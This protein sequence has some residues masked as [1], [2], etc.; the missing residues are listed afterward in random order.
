VLSGRI[1][2]PGTLRDVFGR[3]RAILGHERNIQ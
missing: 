3:Q 2:Q 1:G